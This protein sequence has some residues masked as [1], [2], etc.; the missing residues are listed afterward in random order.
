MGGCASTQAAEPP[1]VPPVPSAGPE[2]H[3]AAMVFDALA[4][5]LEPA[6]RSGVGALILR[7]DAEEPLFLKSKSLDKN[8]LEMRVVRAGGEDGDPLTADDVCELFDIGVRAVHLIPDA[9][10]PAT[11]GWRADECV[12]LRLLAHCAV[13][14]STD[15]SFELR[16]THWLGKIFGAQLAEATVRTVH[17]DCLVSMYIDVPHRFVRIAFDD[18]PEVKWDIEVE[19]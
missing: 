16:S 5:S 3:T 11:W 4:S 13:R 19:A 14:L 12:V 6:L 1:L 18:V 10:M 2:G 17:V 15:V 7:W 8:D 9:A